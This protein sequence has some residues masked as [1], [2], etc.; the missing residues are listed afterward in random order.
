M[1]ILLQLFHNQSMELHLLFSTRVGLDYVTIQNR[2]LKLDL[3]STMSQSRIEFWNWI[4]NFLFET[5]CLTFTW[6]L[7][8]DFG[9]W[10][11]TLDSDL[12]CDNT[13]YKSWNSICSDWLCF[14]WWRYNSNSDN[15]RLTND[16]WSFWQENTGKLRNISSY[17]AVVIPHFYIQTQTKVSLVFS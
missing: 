17:T 7:D 15:Y 12:D 3:D 2:I 5:M 6:T 4:F 16:Y 13:W 8:L 9:L 14:S 11:W 1:M 10:N